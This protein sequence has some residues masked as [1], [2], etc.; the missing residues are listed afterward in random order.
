MYLQ[1]YTMI[2]RINIYIIKS[3]RKHK[4][5][6]ETALYVN[7]N[8]HKTIFRKGNWFQIRLFDRKYKFSVEAALFLN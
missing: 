6:D 3:N 1:L 4:F 7:E 8:T 2:L 5:S